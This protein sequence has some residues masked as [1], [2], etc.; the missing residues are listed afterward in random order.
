MSR[1]NPGVA[2]LLSA[3]KKLTREVNDQEICRRLEIL[4]NSEKEDLPPS[5]V[6]SLLE[7][8]ADFDPSVV[9]EPYT[10]YV[11]HYLYMVKREER[12]KEKQRQETESRKQEKATR[13]KGTKKSVRSAK[14]KSATTTASKKASKKS[15]GT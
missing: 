13:K 7:D 1:S 10:Q 8:P 9:S 15:S 2:R 6:K 3:M 12:N 5:S 14:K 11:K 4:I